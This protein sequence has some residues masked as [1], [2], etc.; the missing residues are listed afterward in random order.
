AIRTGALALD[1]D[2][3]DDV[4]LAE[5]QRLAVEK[6][7]AQAAKFEGGL[8]NDAADDRVGNGFGIDALHFH[9]LEQPDSVLV[10][11]AHGGSMLAPFADD[12]IAVD[13]AELDVG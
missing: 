4:R 3:I 7:R 13:D 12:A 1:L 10:G 2:A 9:E 6:S 11:R 8:G 5:H